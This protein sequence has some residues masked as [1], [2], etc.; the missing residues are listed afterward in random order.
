MVKFRENVCVALPRTAL[1]GV[2]MLLRGGMAPGVLHAA[3]LR[4][5]PC[6]ETLARG[7]LWRKEHVRG[8]RGLGL[9]PTRTKTTLDNATS[10]TS[11]RTA[12]GVVS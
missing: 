8:R 9:V 10:G 2:R 3:D 7:I 12:S 1:G 6:S 11:T 4:R 5:W